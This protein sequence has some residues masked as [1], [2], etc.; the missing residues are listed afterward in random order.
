MKQ[1][2][3]LSPMLFNAIVEVVVYRWKHRVIDRG[4]LVDVNLPRLQATR[5]A[6][7]VILYA[8]SRDEAQEML[9]LFQ[10]ELASMGLQLN[11]KKTKM[12][13][14][15]ISRV[16]HDCISFVNIGD[17]F[18]ELFC[19]SDCH[20]VLGKDVNLT[21]NRAQ[22]EIAHR[23]RLAWASFYNH[24]KALTNRD[25]SL[26]LRLRLFH[27]VVSPVALFGLSCISLT[28][29]LLRKIDDVQRRMLHC[30]VS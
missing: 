9:S 29:G 2:D 20:R 28:D 26:R 24:S 22:I 18:V 13:T 5:F 12:L 11:M 15:D 25:V 17:D 4:W 16:D 1:G 19:S 8:R 10:I 23:L 27:S 21:Q 7:D 6:D 3:I 30:I 14:N